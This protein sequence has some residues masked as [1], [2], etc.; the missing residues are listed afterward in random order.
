MG[1]HLPT[2]LS[3]HGDFSAH[4]HTMKQPTAPL[5]FLLLVLLGEIQESLGLKCW[6]T[7]KSTAGYA[8][9]TSE[10]S[11]HVPILEK[12]CH[13][14]EVQCMRE[15]YTVSPTS[16]VYFRLGCSLPN[17]KLLLKKDKTQEQNTT[18]GSGWHSQAYCSEDF[19]NTP[20]TS[21]STNPISLPRVSHKGDIRQAGILTAPVMI[22]VLTI[23]V[24]IATVVILGCILKK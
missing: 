13:V 14:T 12:S 15:S 11:A 7:G 16:D 21:Q 6:H 8:L 4:C 24:I 1:A 2:E 19:C 20:P 18:R 17:L 3:T 5:H 22:L 9:V 23:V 10:R